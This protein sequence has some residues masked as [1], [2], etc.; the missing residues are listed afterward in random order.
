VGRC[1]VGEISASVQG[2]ARCNEKRIRGITAGQDRNN[3]NEAVMAGDTV[4][5][6][7]E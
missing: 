2:L 5:F 3:G 1:F 6:Q 7:P 4:S